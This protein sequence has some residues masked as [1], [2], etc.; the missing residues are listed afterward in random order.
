MGRPADLIAG[1]AGGDLAGMV[2]GLRQGQVQPDELL[3]HRVRAAPYMAA[4]QEQWRKSGEGEVRRRVGELAME[5]LDVPSAQI[6]Q[7]WS[8]IEE[9]Y[10][11]VNRAGLR[12][13][14]P[15]KDDLA[16]ITEVERRL[17]HEG[18]LRESLGPLLAGL[19]LT[20]GHRLKGLEGVRVAELGEGRVAMALAEQLGYGPLLGGIEADRRQVLGWVTALGRQYLEIGGEAAEK[21]L[22]GSGRAMMSA[23]FLDDSLRELMA[24]RGQLVKQWVMRLGLARPE[25][26]SSKQQGEKIRVGVIGFDWEPRTETYTTLPVIESL[27]QDRF[28]VVLFSLQEVAPDNP[29]RRLETE[30][31]VVL[32][33]REL[34]ELNQAVERVRG[35]NLDVLIF[36][37]NTT[38]T[39]SMMT[40]L[41]SVRL[42]KAQVTFF[43]SP[44]TTGLTE[45]D[46]YVSGE[47][48]EGG[49]SSEVAGRYTERLELLPGA[50]YCAS[51]GYFG[52]PAGRMGVT[53]DAL[54]LRKDAVV[55]ASGA[56]VYKLVPE[57]R[58]AWAEVLRWVEGSQLLL[59]PYAPSWA[60]SYSADAWKRE[61]W[62]EMDRLGVARERLRWVN[63]LAGR[64][65]VEEVLGLADVY[66][67]SF[68]YTGANSVIDG[69]DAGL[70]V[71]TYEGRVMR[72]R[73][74]AAILQE[75]RLQETVAKSA[76]EYVAIAVRLGKENGWRDEVRRKVREGME[77]PEKPSFLDTRRYS[78]KCGVLLERIAREFDENH[79]K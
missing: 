2:R 56:V 24:V 22:M 79:Q 30:G 76:E 46:V 3:A 21:F 10:V 70:P 59:L 32:L 52:G 31:K 39:V 33:P 54:G 11:A 15:T 7:V 71:V 67:D 41:G 34:E 40:L 12:E 57:V 75:L 26:A 20:W 9:C 77:K 47:A 49:T 17:L 43:S 65:R 38:A 16:V 35:E 18:S 69:L 36:G 29:C 66:L 44:V 63:T 50:G 19:L 51:Y 1:W 48:S 5:L 55:F 58:R 14:K 4:L 74:G 61:M 60:G 73:Q 78:E 8:V 37:G 53:R 68:P 64:E 72:C 27:D 62:D 23:Y 42:A 28:E 45:M 25:E 13:Y 6:E